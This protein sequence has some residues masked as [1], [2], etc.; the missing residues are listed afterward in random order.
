MRR[1]N[2]GSGLKRKLCAWG[3]V[4]VSLLFFSSSIWATSSESNGTDRTDRTWRL[5]S[6]LSEEELARLDLSTETPRDPETPYLPAEPYPFTPPYTAEEIGFRSMEFP[7]MP[8]WSCVQIEDAVVLTSSGYLFIL[9]VIV[10]VEY[11]APEGLMGQLTAKPGEV[12]SR[13]L[14]QDIKP[15]EN[16]GNQMLFSMYRTDK[17]T[18]KKADLFGYSRGPAPGAS[19]SSASSP[20]KVS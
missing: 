20:R 4:C 18:I 8:R 7:H 1:K 16:H 5:L 10:L 3:L 12:Y 15:P 9:E 6:E 17:E 13:W 11:R 19:L 14:T 2:F